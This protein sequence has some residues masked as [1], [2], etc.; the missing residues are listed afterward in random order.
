MRAEGRHPICEYGQLD[1]VDDNI[2]CTFSTP[3]FYD[4]G[5]NV[6]RGTAATGPALEDMDLNCPS[7]SLPTG[8][9]VAQF[10]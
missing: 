2:K 10:L 5:S 3:S 1:E 9:M 7:P 8:L 4:A 6:V